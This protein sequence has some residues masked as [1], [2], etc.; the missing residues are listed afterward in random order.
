MLRGVFPVALLVLAAGADAA[1]VARAAGGFVLRHEVT[2]AAPPSRVYQALSDVSAWWDPDHTYSGDAAKLSLDARAGGCFCEAL[3][4]GGSVEHMRVVFA[5]PGR[6]LRLAGGLGPLQGMGV[7]GAMD[8]ALAEHPGGT[9]LVF[10]YSVAGFAPDGLEAMAEP[11]DG[12]LAIQLGR[13]AAHLE[14]R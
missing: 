3:A 2:F 1:V 9:R 10:T 13:L 11:V 6:L 7:S 4:G 8:F 14:A 12:V 5:A